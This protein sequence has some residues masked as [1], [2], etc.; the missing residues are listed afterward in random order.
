MR[1]RHQKRSFNRAREV[2]RR[3]K[4]HRRFYP[5]P[6]AA[7][8]FISF[9]RFGAE[10]RSVSCRGRIGRK[11]SKIRSLLLFELERPAATPEWQR[12]NIS[13]GCY[14]GDGLV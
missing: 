13:A 2:G 3:H 8:S 10:R 9:V 14:S 11:Q 4:D 12:R 5:C 1:Q 6:D 7:W